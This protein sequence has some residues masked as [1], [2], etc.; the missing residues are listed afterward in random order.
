MQVYASANMMYR[1][2][3]TYIAIRYKQV[4]RVVFQLGTIKIY[5]LSCILICYIAG[6]VHV[7]MCTY[8]CSL[9]VV[10]ACLP[11]YN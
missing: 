5:A 11:S 1:R 9:L 8:E 7:V 2:I 6:E 3:Y 10:V 4:G